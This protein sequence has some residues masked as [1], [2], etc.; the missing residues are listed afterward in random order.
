MW[1]CVD[2]RLFTEKCMRAASLGLLTAL[3]ANNLH[4]G[5]GAT[6]HQFDQ[7]FMQAEGD[8][9]VAFIALGSQDLVALPI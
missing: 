1:R 9:P 7:A 5:V 2:A 4:S 8:L 6:A 3:T